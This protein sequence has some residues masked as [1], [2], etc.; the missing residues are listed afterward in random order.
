MIS[1]PLSE[2]GRA[3]AD[4]FR[5]GLWANLGQ[6]AAL[7]GLLTALGASAVGIAHV[8]AP[9]WVSMPET[10]EG[11]DKRL[12]AIDTKL[13]ELDTSG[14]TRRPFID[15]DGAYGFPDVVKPGQRVRV[16]YVVRINRPC[17]MQVD[18]RWWSLTD[19][20]YDSNFHERVAGLPLG[21]TFDQQII[22]LRME[23]PALPEGTWAYHPRLFCPNELPV[24]APPVFFDVEPAGPNPDRTP[25]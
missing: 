4:A 20:G 13:A 1:V 16:A 19:S 12:D 18:R 10:V 15:F 3:N 2:N 14:I 21:A 24:S 7:G 5:R 17:D 25:Q 23:I 22:V 8:V 9:K 6:L 11:M